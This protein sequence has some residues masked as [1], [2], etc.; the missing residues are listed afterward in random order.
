MR[1]KWPGPVP[2]PRIDTEARLA[3]QSNNVSANLG[4]LASIIYHSV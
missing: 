1:V 3:R 4:I 2:T